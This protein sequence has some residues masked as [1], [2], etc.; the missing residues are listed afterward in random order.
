MTYK[1]TNAIIACSDR[2]GSLLLE[3]QEFVQQQAAS[4]CIVKA[5]KRLELQVIIRYHI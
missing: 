2:C 5:I 3:Q 1:E 4:W